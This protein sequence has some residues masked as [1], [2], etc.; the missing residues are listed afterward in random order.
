VLPNPVTDT[1]E[2]PHTSADIRGSAERGRHGER[3]G[4]HIEIFT[5]GNDL[6]QFR[7]RDRLVVPR[8]KELHRVAKHRADLRAERRRDALDASSGTAR[9]GAPSAAR[10]HPVPRRLRW[11]A[12][13]GAFLVVATG[14]AT[15]TLTGRPT[16]LS[17]TTSSA[18]TVSLA[19]ERAATAAALDRRE[20]AVS[21]DATRVARVQVAEQ[22]LRAVTARAAQERKVALAALAKK[23]QR[24]AEL[25]AARE[26]AERLAAR[27]AWHLPV[28]AGAYHLTSRFGECSSLWSSCHTGLDFAAPSGTP[29]RAVA[30]GR[31]L[32]VSYAGAY[33]NRTRMRL[34]DG[35]EVW[36]CHQTS[37]AV[38]VG[39]QVAGGQVI[40]TVGSTGNST[41][42]HL[43]L[44]VR[45]TPKTPVDP[46]AALAAHDLEP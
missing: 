22:R 38:E 32:E 4:L 43:H 37:T 3:D 2:V 9:S 11:V 40:G 15:T 26:R 36:Y 33:G 41:G 6:A 29:I 24:Q 10:A 1:R 23:A 30:A 44:E 35:T 21:R 45:P 18:A 28:A 27:N 17:V 25:I 14:A 39:Q 34:S 12:L 13:V 46:F 20:R 5:V 7:Y 8:S 42:P 16:L 31:I 19:A